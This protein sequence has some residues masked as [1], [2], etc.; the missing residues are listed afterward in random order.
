MDWAAERWVRLYCCRSPKWTCLGF[1][2]RSVIVHVLQA[3]DTEGAVYIGSEEP[4]RWASQVFSAP[5]DLAREGMARAFEC[6]I[7]EHR[8]DY[9]VMP[10]FKTSQAAASDDALRK[11]ESRRRKRDLA[12]RHARTPIHVTKRDTESMSQNVTS[13]TNGSLSTHVN[14]YMSQSHG[15]VRDAS[16]VNGSPYEDDPS[17]IP[18][19]PPTPWIQMIKVWERAAFAGMPSGDPHAHKGRLETLWEACKARS[20]SDPLGVFRRAAE[21]YCAAQQGKRKKPNLRWFASDF[22][23]Y[24]DVVNGRRTSPL[25]EELERTKRLRAQAVQAGDSES[26][27]RLDLELGRIG[28][29]MTAPVLG[30]HHG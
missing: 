4:W 2:G 6:G 26:A 17:Q 28:R 23:E 16:V 19:P 8:G 9:L 27:K 10:E 13:I 15:R 20:A 22:E 18:L 29:A 1:V 25:I 5:A 21:A 24:A 7:L 12:A 30:G 3:L 11:R 14:G